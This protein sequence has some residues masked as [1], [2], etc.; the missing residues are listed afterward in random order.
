M[1]LRIAL[2][3]AVVAI[4][5]VAAPGASATPRVTAS[6]Q[7]RGSELSVNG[8]VL[9]HPTT[10]KRLTKW[11]AVLEQ[12]GAAGA[13]AQLI[14]TTLAIHG[15]TQRFELAWSPPAS[16]TAL[17]VR[18]AVLNGEHLLAATRSQ[19]V[20][21][22]PPAPTTCGGEVPAP[23]PGGG[24]WT[25][26]FD[27]EFNTTTGDPSALDL[28]RWIPQTTD[29]SDYST[30]T[31]GAD[32]CYENTPQT[33]S[34]SGGALHLSVVRS[35]TLHLCGSYL[36]PYIGGMVSTYQRFSQEYGR[37]EVRALLPAATTRGLQETLWLWPV[38]DAL[39]GGWPGS[40][41]V[42]FSEFFSN[43][44]GVDV[45][46]LHYNYN[47]LSVDAATSTNTVTNSG[48]PIVQGQYN[49][50]AVVWTPGS[51]TITVNGATCLVDNYV[52]NGGLSAPAP[53]NQPFMVVLT[54][55]LG[56]G[57]NAFDPLLTSLPA[58]MSIEYVRVW[59]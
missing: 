57:T 28:D 49:D 15:K 39:Y 31:F 20:K 48:C 8:V 52:P 10:R 4:A 3:A 33:I 30:G 51:F 16:A 26:T 41:E 17:V 44:S 32:V 40:G 55:A 56:S 59:S 25:C 27:D 50:Y 23:K 38:D 1:R 7:L 24:T 42:D 19:E 45:P 14:G 2:I 22:A 47:P 18:V 11:R 35:S 6:I 29:N 21:V 43:D 34:V 5:L 53:F 54:Q 58:T 37:Y 9:R 46:H 13:W 36:T 12:R